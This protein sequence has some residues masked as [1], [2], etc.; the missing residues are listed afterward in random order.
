MRIERHLERCKL[1]LI[2]MLDYMVMHDLY[3]IPN[4]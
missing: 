2:S 3:L 4:I 1:R